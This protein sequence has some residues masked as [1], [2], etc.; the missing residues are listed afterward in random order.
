LHARIGTLPGHLDAP[1]DLADIV[2]IVA[3]LAA[4]A[5]AEAVGPMRSVRRRSGALR[6]PT[7]LR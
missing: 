4:V 5:G 2:Q 7:I 3:D 6:N 1:L